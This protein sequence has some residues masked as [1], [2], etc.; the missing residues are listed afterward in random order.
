MA[1]LEFTIESLEAKIRDC[2]KRI[3]INRE[4]LKE[5]GNENNQRLVDEVNK[6][7]KLILFFQREL[8]QKYKEKSP[9]SVTLRDSLEYTEMYF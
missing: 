3:I 2:Q 6:L 7:K 8:S 1:K 4:L 9:D 5:E